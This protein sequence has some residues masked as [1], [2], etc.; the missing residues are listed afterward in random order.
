MVLK[1]HIFMRDEVIKVQKLQIAVLAF[2]DV[3]TPVYEQL[4]IVT[5]SRV[6][7][8]LIG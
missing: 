8:S 5:H 6:V 4:P 2:H 1:L 7:T 3:L